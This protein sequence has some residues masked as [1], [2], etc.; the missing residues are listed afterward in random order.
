MFASLLNFST[1]APVYMCNVAKKKYNFY[2]KYAC[3]INNS[4]YSNNKLCC[5]IYIMNCDLPYCKLN[6]TNQTARFDHS[7][8]THTLRW[9]CLLPLQMMPCLAKYTIPW[10]S[11]M[12]CWT[13]AQSMSPKY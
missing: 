2:L 4:H 7:G 9:A 13:M 5:R 8:L 1:I 3:A 11:K 6:M 12:P 10:M